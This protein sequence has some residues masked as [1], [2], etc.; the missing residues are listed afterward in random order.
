MVSKLFKKVS[1]DLTLLPHKGLFVTL[2]L[3]LSMFVTFELTQNPLFRLTK[4]DEIE[5]P[6]GYTALQYLEALGQ[7]DTNNDGIINLF[8]YAVL[9]EQDYGK[10]GAFL[11]SD[12]NFDQKANA[13]DNSFMLN[14]FYTDVEDERTKIFSSEQY[15]QEVNKEIALRNEDSVPNAQLDDNT[16]TITSEEGGS[17]PQFGR[18][19]IPQVLGTVSA[20]TGAASYSM[21]FQ[22]PAGPGGL[23]PALGISYSSQSIDDARNQGSDGGHPF[24]GE[25]ESYAPYQFGYGFSLSGIGSIMRDTKEEKEVYKL[26]GKLYHRYILNLPG[27]I[28]AEL[29][30]NAE[31]GR[32][33]SIPQSFLKIEHR[34]PGKVTLGALS[35]LDPWDWKVTTKDGTT[36][37]FGEEN[38]E[39]KLNVDGRIIGSEDIRDDQDRLV[40]SKNGNA[41]VEFDTANL[42]EGD[43]ERDPCRKREKDGKVLIVTKWLLRKVESADGRAIN[44]TYDSQQQFLEKPWKDTP[45]QF[46]SS[47]S[48]P[49]EISW[50]DGKH[51][52]QFA[53][54]EREDKG[55]GGFMRNRIKEVLVETKTQEDDQFHLVRKYVLGYFDTNVKTKEGLGEKAASEGTKSGEGIHNDFKASFLTSIQ[56]FG[57]DNVTAL[58][59]TTFRYL[60][61]RFAPQNYKGGEIYLANINN[62]YGGETRFA[63]QPVEVGAFDPDGKP[64]SGKNRRVRVIQKEVADLVTNKSSRETYDYGQT[65]LFEENHREAPVGSGGT[66]QEYLGHASVEIKQ[67]DFDNS[68]LGHTETF[69]N[70]VNWGENCFE[71]HPAKGQPYRQ[72]VYRGDTKDVAQESSSTFR[73]RFDGKDGQDPSSGCEKDR[74]NQP[75]FLYT[76]DTVS[77][78]REAAKDFVPLA[79]K[80]KVQG[81]SKTELRTLQRVLAHDEYGNQTLSVNY[82]EVDGNGIDVVKDDNRYSYA[83]YLTSGEKWIKGL[84]HLSYASTTDTCSPENLTCQYGRTKSY[85]DNFDKDYRTLTLDQMQPQF[86]FLTQKETWIDDTHVTV[87][88]YE[89]DD[90]SGNAKDADVRKGGVTRTYGPKPNIKTV[91]E[92]KDDIILTSEKAYDPYY[93]TLLLEEKN[94]LQHKVKYEDYDPLLQTPRVVKKQIQ[95]TPE[96]YSATRMEFDSLGRMLAQFSPDPEKPGSTFAEPAMLSYFFER[97]NEGLVVRSAAL[98]SQLPNGTKTYQVSDEFYDGLGQVR[99]SQVLQ[100]SVEGKDMRKIS[101]NEYHADGKSTKTFEMQIASPVIIESINAQNYRTVLGTV[102]PQFATGLPRII[103][104][105]TQLD[106]LRRPIS[107]TQIETVTGQKFT[108]TTEYGI[109]ST[110]SVDPKGVEKIALSDVWGRGIRAFT[111]DATKQKSL[112]TANEYGKP[113]SDKATK[114]TII[115]NK[116]DKV[117]SLFDYDKAGRLTF[118]QDPSL[119]QYRFEYDIYGNKLLEISQPR[120]DV[121]YSYDL[122]GRMVKKTYYSLSN[123]ELYNKMARNEVT[124][125]YDTSGFGLGKLHRVEHLTGSKEFTYDSGQRLVTTRVSTFSNSKDFTTGY[126]QLSQETLSSYPDGTKLAKEYDREGR[127][128]K[129]SIDGKPIFSGAVYDKFGNQRTAN[130][131]FQGTQYTNTNSF[132]TLGRLTQLG[133]SKKQAVLGAGIVDSE[134]FKQEL[135]Y[136]SVAEIEKLNDTVQGQ[137]NLYNYGYDGFS[138]LTS[139][140]S[141]LYTSSYEYD[142][143]GRMLK[144]KEKDEVTM[145]YSSVYP[146]FAPKK[147]NVTGEEP[148]LQEPEISPTITLTPTSIPTLTPTLT[149]TTQ[150]GVTKAQPIA[151]PTAVPTTDPVEQ[152]LGITTR[153]YDIGYTN[154]GGMRSDENNCYRYNREGELTFLG[155]KK[156]KIGD[157]AD[158]NFKNIY[159]FYYDEGGAMNLQEEY[160]PSNLNNPLKQIYLFGMYEEEITN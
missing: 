144:K 90:L 66:A 43:S 30:Y 84:S 103:N 36:Y 104:A 73:Y 28:S 10:Q 72:V 123:G 131:E 97:G 134:I 148:I 150:P 110:K 132:D 126:N 37:F 91:A 7:S 135:S 22:V 99:Q 160:S 87:E 16:L 154:E 119:G 70:Q 35:Y 27:G 67:Y 3:L 33:V 4:A 89:Y 101:E 29:K 50:N 20:Y 127:M 17:E 80:D 129:M 107:S 116:G 158:S 57:T 38:I 159:M 76:Y 98:S 34:S 93:H 118:S 92:P 112:M 52:V 47:S 56:E 24:Y 109:Q 65:W 100:T 11:A 54:Q 155:Q 137:A 19:V 40:G 26:K 94:T 140:A 44:Y 21:N 142:L 85:Y 136:N 143:F 138:Q 64:A 45:I 39:S 139:V 147:V 149:P 124:Y 1:A 71:P 2:F 31:T 25:T 117:E 18:N 74:R 96:A 95:L 121:G 68:L 81:G 130:V 60:Q 128:A 13:L 141:P 106:V 77:T 63:Y 111:Q 42:C 113:L 46:V 156:N 115:D 145:T 120:E 146:F 105:E 151:L 12:V 49:K 78:Q 102:Q 62:G 48:Y 153:S 69:F 15:V 122:L 6:E 53:T 41:Y 133:V 88:G 32:W 55:R 51:R 152:A 9:L 58:P 5:L 79:F 108:S 23:A 14:H 75:L 59:P 8:D 86:G 82:G 157:C 114:T 125:Q 83:Y 61:Y